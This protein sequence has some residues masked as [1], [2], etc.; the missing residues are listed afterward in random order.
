MLMPG[1]GKLI[2]QTGNVLL[3][4]NYCRQVEG[5]SA[6]W[7]TMLAVSDTGIG[8]DV[9]TQTRIFEPFYTTKELGKGT[10]LGLA[11]VYGIVRQSGGHV[12]VYSEPNMGATFKVYL[13]HAGA[14]IPCR[15]QYLHFLTPGVV[16][17]PYC[18]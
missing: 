3:D 16:M 15:N 8:M 4:E 9:E 2:I 1:G 13:P 6:G 5:M 12:A 14:E 17:R 10:G 7:Y 11:T 18:W